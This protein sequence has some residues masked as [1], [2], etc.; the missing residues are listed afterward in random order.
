MPQDPVPGLLSRAT[1]LLE[2]QFA[3]LPA[4]ASAADPAAT[5]PAATPPGATRAKGSSRSSRSHHTT[6]EVRDE[7]L[8][9]VK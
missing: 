6:H 5:P 4:F 3:A 1:E 8:E 9:I 7:E 2:E